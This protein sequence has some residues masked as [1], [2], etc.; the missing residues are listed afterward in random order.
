LGI[1]GDDR[2]QPDAVIARVRKGRWMTI[3]F[4]PDGGVRETRWWPTKT[5]AEAWL[6]M[7]LPVGAVIWR[8]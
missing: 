2:E 7:R 4:D 6:G 8:R 5:A 1:D 3:L